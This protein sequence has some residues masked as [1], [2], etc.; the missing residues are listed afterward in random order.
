LHKNDWQMPRKSRRE[1]ITVA[2]RLGMPIWPR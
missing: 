2:A 1:M